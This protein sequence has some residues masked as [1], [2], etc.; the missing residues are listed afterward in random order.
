MQDA[1]DQLNQWT[2]SFGKKMLLNDKE[3]TSE[4]IDR[5]TRTVMYG[6]HLLREIASCL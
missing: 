6:Y 1:E 4:V 5:K 3:K 2:V